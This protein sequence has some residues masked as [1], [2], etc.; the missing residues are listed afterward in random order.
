MR[1][2]ILGGDG[3]L[4]HQLML[5]YRHKHEVKVTLR[6]SLHEYDDLGLYSSD[7]SYENIDVPSI[8][9]L[10]NVVQD[11]RPDAIINAI[12]IIKQHTDIEEFIPI[13]QINALFPHNLALLCKKLGVRL[14]HVS[15][16]CIFS[17]KKGNYHETDYADAEDLY[18]ISK[19]LGEVNY[20]NCITLRMRRRSSRG[21]RVR[22][23]SGLT[24]SGSRSRDRS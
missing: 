16:D 12:G 15:T 23:Q 24:T 5:S 3:M 19:Y 1:I 10:Q 20:D 7:N 14:V 11:F 2:L 9:N 21:F 22:N 17:G 4:G 6:R 8:T 13:L 18:G